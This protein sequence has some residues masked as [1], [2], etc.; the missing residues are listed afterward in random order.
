LAVSHN[1]PTLT[2]SDPV[3]SCFVASG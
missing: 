2:R 1:A 3:P